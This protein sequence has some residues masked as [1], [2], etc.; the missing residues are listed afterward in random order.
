MYFLA[1]L[2]F[3]KSYNVTDKMQAGP[4]KLAEEVAGLNSSKTRVHKI[5]CC[6][7]RPVSATEAETD[8][9]EC[10]YFISLSSAAS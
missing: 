10:V 6:F 1:K 2:N 8:A 3:S 7:F 4:A 9:G 5:E